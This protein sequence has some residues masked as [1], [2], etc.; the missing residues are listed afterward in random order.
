MTEPVLVVVVDDGLTKGSLQETLREWGFVPIEAETA[1]N[2]LELY[3]SESPAITLLDMNLP[4]GSGL[5]VLREIR[6]REPDAVVIMT[7]S[8]ASGHDEA[9]LAGV[10]SFVRRP[11]DSEELRLAL[12]NGIETRA[13]RREAA[14]MRHERTEAFGFG[15]IIGESSAMSKVK[16]LA[17]KAAASDV[18]SVLLQGESGTG[19]DLVAKAIHFSS[20][21]ERRPFVSVNC[22]AIPS[23]LL[24]IKLFGFERGAFT[25]AE[26]RKE[27]LFE[28]AE[29]GTLFLDEIGELEPSLQAK[30][31]RVLE[32]GAFRRVGGLKDIPFD[33]RV[34]TASSRD[35]KSDSE[36]GTFRLDLYYRLSMRQIDIPAL[37]ERGEDVLLLAEHFTRMLD[38]GRR[39][40]PRPLARETERAFLSY[41]WPGN[42]SELR[43]AIERALILNETGPISL[44]HM[45]RDLTA[46]GRLPNPTA[47]DKSSRCVYLPPEGIPLEAVEQALINQA[48]ERSGGNITKAGELLHISRDR[49]RYRMKKGVSGN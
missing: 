31:L 33:L 8:D 15:R 25:D 49:V 13:L 11:I 48:L 17:Q 22:A 45:P 35:L 29:G 4:D 18:S 43:N 36:A 44:R 9:V 26:A 3:R 12:R 32:A 37:R 1:A 7:T 34:V 14:R 19:K 16:A 21:R 41:H 40:A 27:G 30:L 6:R 28:Q 10:H 39:G 46:E 2:A 5:D 20:A 47:S 23:T 38:A 42:V 24:E